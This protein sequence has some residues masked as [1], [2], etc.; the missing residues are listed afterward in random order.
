MTTSRWQYAKALAEQLRLNGVAEPK[1]REIVA[2]VEA[3]T[4]ATGEDPVDAFGQPVVYAA[5]WKRLT[6][7]RWLGQVL[8]GVGASLGIVGVSTT[9]TAEGP[10]GGV[11]PIVVDDVT[12]L[13][14]SVVL[15][16]LLPWT[17]DLWVS[18]RR[19]SRL[20]VGSTRHGWPVRAGVVIGI[21]TVAGFGMWLFDGP[22]PS[23]T[24]FEVPRWSL[25]AVAL[26]SIPTL[27]LSGPAPGQNTHPR[28]PG[29]A[30][31]PPPWPAR[32]RR[33]LTNR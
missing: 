19:A 27:F 5:Q 24:L 17:A 18:R 1:V 4:K 12:L 16:A 31:D 7:R 11:V 13:G 23:Q 8:L 28:P 10:W 14:V 3:H 21:A 33:A 25:L 29:P 32:I 26:A 2:Q 30:G 6:P 22:E 20:G 15:L 9:V